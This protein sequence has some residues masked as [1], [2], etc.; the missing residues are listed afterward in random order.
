MSLLPFG[1]VLAVRRSAPMPEIV[2]PLPFADDGK[3]SLIREVP[4]EKAVSV[5]GRMAGEAEIWAIA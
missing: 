1:I 3:A 2:S 4:G 5:C